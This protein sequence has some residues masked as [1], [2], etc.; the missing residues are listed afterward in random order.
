MEDRHTHMRSISLKRDKKKKN[1]VL[2]KQ[3]SVTLL[4]DGNEDN[5]DEDDLSECATQ[6]PNVWKKY[7]LL[8]GSGVNIIEKSEEKECGAIRKSRQYCD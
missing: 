8:Q 7:S 4:S 5:T 2:V 6:P 1:N 3:N